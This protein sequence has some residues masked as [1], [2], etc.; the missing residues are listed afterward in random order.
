MTVVVLVGCERGNQEQ[1]GSATYYLSY[2]HSSKSS[3][4]Y[5]YYPHPEIE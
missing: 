2:Y 5:F 1:M 4:P 3:E